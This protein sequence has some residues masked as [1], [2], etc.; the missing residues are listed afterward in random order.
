M[1]RKPIGIRP[2]EVGIVREGN[3]IVQV[4]SKILFDSL[5]LLRTKEN[6]AAIEAEMK[7]TIIGLNRRSA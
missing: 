1:V 3:K 6:C 7:K 5:G 4:Q 2:E